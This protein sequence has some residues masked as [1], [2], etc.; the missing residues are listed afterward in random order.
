LEING[1]SS[2]AKTPPP[3]ATHVIAERRAPGVTP[4]ASPSPRILQAAAFSPTFA[5]GGTAV[6]FHQQR[7]GTSTVHRAERERRR[8]QRDACRPGSRAK[9]PSAA[10]AGRHTHRVRF[11]S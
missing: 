2:G 8:D 4:L 6:Y 3:Q 7:D 9:F 10:V 1:P 11:G 5:R